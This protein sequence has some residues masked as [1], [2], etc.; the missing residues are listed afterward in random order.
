MRAFL[1]FHKVFANVEEFKPCSL[2]NDASVFILLA[3]RCDNIGGMPV[4]F[5]IPA[6]LFDKVNS[7]TAPVLAM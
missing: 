4:F 7:Q 6:Y 3:Y 2:D 5:H 1:Y